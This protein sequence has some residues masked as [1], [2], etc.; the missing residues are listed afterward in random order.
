MRS[1]RGE[2]TLIVIAVLVAVTFVI[3]LWRG[4]VEH[5]A[6]HVVCEN[7]QSEPGCYDLIR[8]QP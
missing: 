3:S 1:D 4:S 2:V 5:V 7:E 8:V 6:V